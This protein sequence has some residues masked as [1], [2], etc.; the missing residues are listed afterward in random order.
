MYWIEIKQ[1]YQCIR[2]LFEDM[3]SVMEFAESIL[4]CEDDK[5]VVSIYYENKKGAE[6]A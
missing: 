1:D 3:P 2:F 4:A 6:R 5:T